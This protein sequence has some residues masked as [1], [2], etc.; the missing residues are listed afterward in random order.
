MLNTEERRFTNV[1]CEYWN[2]LR[3]DRHHPS[4][5]E[6]QK[7]KLSDIW[8][9]CFIVGYLA[10]KYEIVHVGGAIK[11]VCAADF[12]IA[13]D[14]PII[15]FNNIENIKCYLDEVIESTEA[16]IEES[17][18]YDLEGNTVKFRQCFLPLGKNENIVDAV[19]GVM[20]YKVY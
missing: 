10:S 14:A 17:E 7:N 11:D 3:G 20:R 5:A 12:R 8:D 4:L 9:H 13:N 15:H 2:E 19:L 6:V 16:V 1:L 18:C